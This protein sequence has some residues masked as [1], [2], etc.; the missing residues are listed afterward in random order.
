MLLLVLTLLA[1]SPSTVHLLLELPH[2]KQPLCKAASDL[3]DMAKLVLSTSKSDP[4]A[5]EL[6]LP[7]DI[8]DASTRVLKAVRLFNGTRQST[9]TVNSASSSL[10]NDYVSTL[11]DHLFQ[12]VSGFSSHY[13]EKELKSNSVFP[14]QWLNRVQGEFVDLKNALPLHSDSA[15]LLRVNERKMSLGKM[16]IFPAP[17][18]PYA[19]GCFVFDVFFPPGYPNEAPKVHLDTTGRNTFRF[20]PNLYAEGKVCLSLLGTWP[21]HPS[22]MWNSLSTFLQVAVSILSL[23]FIEN[24][25]YN[26]PGHEQEVKNQNQEISHAYNAKRRNATIRFAMLEQIRNPP[27]GF[28]YAVL[29]H[30]YIHR[31][32]IRAQVEGWLSD[33]KSMVLQLGELCWVF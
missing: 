22:E 9:L 10:A 32:T 12:L 13:Y 33:G 15:V 24:P 19:R 8:M 30:F 3:R 20:N 27:K 11:K 28:E 7:N 21:G 6:T 17:G 14:K 31:S 29:S 25:M 26:E 1:E 4:G 2:Q 18:T 23:I 16:V 5:V